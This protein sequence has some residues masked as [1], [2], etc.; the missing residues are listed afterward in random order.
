[1]LAEVMDSVSDARQGLPIELFLFVSQLTP[2][3]NVDLLIKNRDGQTLMTWRED[4]FYGPGWHI[5]GGVIRFKEAAKHRIAEVAKSELGAVVR[6][7]EHPLLVRE[8]VAPHRDVRGHFMSLLYRCELVSGPY[9]GLR[10]SAA[11]PKHGEWEWLDGCPDQ[12]IWQHEVYR[13][14]IDGR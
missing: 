10:R 3:V 8:L 13:A 6:A 2:L 4:E 5:P 1:L 11:R 7:E 14:V 12:I 9:D